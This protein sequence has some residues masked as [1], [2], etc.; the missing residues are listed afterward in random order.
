[1]DLS[2]VGLR[3]TLGSGGVQQSDVVGLSVDL[4][5]EG[6]RGGVCRVWNDKGDRGDCRLKA[7]SV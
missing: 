7:V 1:M 6:L 5:A 2:R 4:D 3:V